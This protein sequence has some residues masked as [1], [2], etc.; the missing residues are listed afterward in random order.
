METHD[1]R[2]DLSTLKIYPQ[3]E[4]SK[5]FRNEKERDFMEQL[6]GK[7]YKTKDL[8]DKMSLLLEPLL[9][10]NLKNLTEA[11]GYMFYFTH[12]WD[13]YNHILSSSF[14][15]HLYLITDGK[16]IKIG[17]SKDVERRLGE[18]QVT[19]PYELK[20]LEV[21]PHRGCYEYILHQYF[22]KLNVRG[23]WFEYSELIIDFIK[24]AQEKTD[25]SLSDK[26]IHLN[27]F[28]QTVSI[29]SK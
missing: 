20:I 27:H 29:S 6:L 17:K 3:D 16:Y 4:V 18:L 26:K 1:P 25:F 19:S 10:Y 9:R 7:F 24:K 5:Y 12:L 28:T 23:E 21:V 11:G 13:F 22:K 2:S 14:T 15:D 8:R